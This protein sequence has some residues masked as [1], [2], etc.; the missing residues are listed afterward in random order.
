MDVVEDMPPC[1]KHEADA[2][3]ATFAWPMASVSE[4]CPILLMLMLMLMLM[5]M[6]AVG[7]EGWLNFCGIC[8]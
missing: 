4:C 2:R 1:E 5:P 6:S 3:A 7:Q 8:R